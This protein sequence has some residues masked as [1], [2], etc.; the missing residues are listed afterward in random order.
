M[1]LA[2]CTSALATA[3]ALPATVA[4]QTEPPGDPATSRLQGEFQMLGRV[5]VAKNI[6]GERRGQKAKRMWTFTS[7]CATGQC[8]TV[9]LVRHRKGGIDRLKL[10]RRS[11]GYYTGKGVFYAPLRCAGKV[12]RKGESV[13]FT[14]T[15]R[16]K[17]AELLDGID[18]AT[19]VHATYTNRARKNLTRCV[20]IPGHDAAVYTGN[21]ATLPTAQSPAGS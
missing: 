7:V 16:I 21:L 4:A 1:A 6:R 20:A 17:G 18:T 5:T 3:I 15:V 14:I 9:R 2:A 12:V 19:S 8:P 10:K 11:A 13:P